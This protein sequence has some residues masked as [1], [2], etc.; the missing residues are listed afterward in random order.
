MSLDELLTMAQQDN[1]PS[2]KARY[3]AYLRSD[4][5]KDLRCEVFARQSDRCEVCN[6]PRHPLHVHHLFYP[7]PIEN[8]KIEHVM[9]LCERCHHS[10]HKH[11]HWY[12]F[13]QKEEDIY[14]IRKWIKENPQFIIKGISAKDTKKVARQV[15][16]KSSEIIAPIDEIRILRLL[17]EGRNPFN[18]KKLKP[19]KCGVLAISV[20]C[21]ALLAGAQA[22]ERV[23]NKENHRNNV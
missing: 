9:V 21:R 20:V 4:L 8:T 7:E 19:K 22:L 5:W 23:G 13:A 11:N 3:D 16:C 1:L 17:S 12:A 18:G 2:R 6:D 10:L 14:K 15:G